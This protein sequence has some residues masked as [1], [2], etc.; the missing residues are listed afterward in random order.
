MLFGSDAPVTT[1][2]TLK[3]CDDDFNSF[4]LDTAATTINPNPLVK[5][6]SV[7]FDIKGIVTDPITVKNVHVHVDWN[8]SPLYDEDHDVE[9]TYDA[10]YDYTL[11]WAVPGFAPDGHYDV[12]LTGTDSDGKVNVCVG[13]Q[14]DF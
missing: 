1:P 4:Q 14:F 8:S 5:G 2:A 6:Q 10:D 11:E 9:K 3:Q 12:K 7:Y 13:A